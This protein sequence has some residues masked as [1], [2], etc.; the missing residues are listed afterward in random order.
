MESCSYGCQ[1]WVKCHKCFV[2]IQAGTSGV[3]HLERE[4]SIMKKVKHE[5]IIHLEEVFETPKVRA[6]TSILFHT[7]LSFK[8]HSAVLL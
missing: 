4:V 5:H 8:A 1:G 6:K 2:S 7:P 3:K